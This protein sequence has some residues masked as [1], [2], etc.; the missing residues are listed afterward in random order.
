[1]QTQN[2][3]KILIRTAAIMLIISKTTLFTACVE[4]HSSADKGN[5]WPE[6]LEENYGTLKALYVPAEGFAYR[7]EQGKLTGVTVELIRDFTAFVNEKYDITLDVKFEKEEDWSV[8]YRRVVEG[9]DGLIG[10]G[11]VTITE[12]RK[13]E[14][15]FS[16]PYMNNI[17]SLITCTEVPE[18]KSVDEL[19]S[20]FEEMEALAFKGTLH[21]NRL[22]KLVKNYYPGTEIKFATSNNEIM[23]RV[24]DNCE[25]FAYIDLYNYF[26]ASK[27]GIPLKRHSI[28]DDTTE[29]FGYIMPLNTTWDEVFEHYFKHNDGLT[30]SARYREIMQKHLGKDLA[31][32]LIDEN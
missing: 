25:Y 6:V 11:N 21:E 32:L 12:E 5:S 31:T 8:F 4:E 13:E 10:F 14:L 16:P 17:A 24:S 7:D 22:R 30:S 2:L 15:T 26:R 18:L 1:M 19:S 23:E 9:G 27:R 3:S 20:T 28:G 29:Q